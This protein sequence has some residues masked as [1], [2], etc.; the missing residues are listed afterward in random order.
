MRLGGC[1][2]P[3]SY[4]PNEASE[5][6]VSWILTAC[7]G[8]E[9]LYLA[10]RIARRN[11]LRSQRSHFSFSLWSDRRLT[12][13][14]YSLISFRFWMVISFALIA[15]LKFNCRFSR[16]KSDPLNCL[17]FQYLNCHRARLEKSVQ[18]V[19]GS[20]RNVSVSINSP[21]PLHSTDDGD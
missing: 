7:L 4:L 16:P 12:S 20:K 9:G 5:S 14:I 15:K 1:G 2:L 11:I 8:W 18:T 21:L 3:P 10:P 17:A 6:P 13:K 19:W